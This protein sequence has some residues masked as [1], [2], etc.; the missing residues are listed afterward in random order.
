MIINPSESTVHLDDLQGWT[1]LN[2]NEQKI[3][4]EKTH[5]VIEA[6]EMARQ[7]EVLIGKHLSEIRA[8]LLPYKMWIAYLDKNFGWSV[9][10]AYNYIAGYE[11]ATRRN[12]EKPVLEAALKR[13]F[14]QV[15]MEVL[16]ANPLPPEV[17][18][19]IAIG[20]HLDKVTQMPRPVVE[21][22]YDG[23]MREA[24]NFI[25]AR[26][27]KIPDNLRMEWLRLLFGMILTRIG[28]SAAQRFEPSAIPDHFRALRGR[29]MG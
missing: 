28:L 26:F 17:T 12:I 22:D 14:R 1:R 10:T 16:E 9:A 13:G 2:T 29:R 19:P 3:V 25:G 7:S 4:R 20:R 8:I 15:H 5:T 6:K 11:K 23:S 21:H 18:D 27:Y 24:F